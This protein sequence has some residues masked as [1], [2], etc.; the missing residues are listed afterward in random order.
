MCLYQVRYS[1]STFPDF[2]VHDVESVLLELRQYQLPHEIS[3][4]FVDVIYHPPLADNNTQDYLISTVDKLLLVHP[5]AGVTIL[6][7]FNQ[8]DYKT[9]LRHFSLKQTVRKPTRQSTLL[10]RILTN[11]QK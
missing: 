3:C 11:M 8:F 2:S 1:I 6:D 9:L 4:I 5:K 7:D 10:D